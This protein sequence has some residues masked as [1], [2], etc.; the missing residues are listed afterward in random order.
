MP[1]TKVAILGL[2]D[3]GFLSA[4][5][6]HEKGY[7]VFASDLADT[8]DVRENVLKLVKRGIRA[9]CGKHSMDAILALSGSDIWA[10]L[11]GI[12]S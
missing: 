10:I 12:E 4:L 1:G 6:L 3:T 5:F 7:Q 8:D 2:R 9:E 11:T